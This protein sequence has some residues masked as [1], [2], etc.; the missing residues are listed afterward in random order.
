MR[1]FLL[2]F[3]L[4]F[5]ASAQTKAYLTHGG[6][7]QVTVMDTATDINLRT[8]LGGTTPSRVAASRDGGRVYVANTGNSTISVIDTLSDTIANTF[9]LS[10]VPNALAVSANGALLYVSVPNSIQVLSTF[11]GAVTASIPVTGTATGLAVTPDG[12][13]LFAAAGRLL[14]ID[15]ATNAVTNTGLA[16]GAT[17]VLVHPKANRVF[18]QINGFESGS[19]AVLDRASLQVTN[20]ILMGSMG[21]MAIS[22]D[23]SRLY[24]GAGT[25]ISCGPYICSVS[26]G[27][28]VSVI[29]TYDLAVAG[30]IPLNGLGP[31]A[32][33]AVTPDRSDVYIVLSSFNQVGVASTSSN[34]LRLQIP[35]AAGANQITILTDPNAPI[36]PYLID[37]VDDVAPKSSSGGT[38]VANV[39][40][41]DRLGGFQARLTNVTLSQVSSTSFGFSLNASTGAAVVAAGTAYGPQSLVYRICETAAPTNCD[42]A[43]VSVSVRA[44]YPIDAVDDSASSNTGRVAI[45]NVLSN[46]TFNGSPAN[47]T[48][49]TLGQVS[50]TTTALV[51][52]ANGSVTVLAGAPKGPQA[53]VYRICEIDSPANCDSATATVTVIP[54][55]IDAVDDTGVTTRAGGIAV[56][57]V[58]VNDTFA[59]S[60][61]TLSRVTLTQVSTSNAGLTL[62]S[63]GSVSAARGIPMGTHTL[64][65]RICETASPSNCDSAAVTVNVTSYVIDAVDDVA[66]G[67]SKSANT[68]L[69]SVLAN[70]T[71]GGVQP[72]TATVSL[73]KVSLTPANSSI[74]LN[75]VDGSVN[76]LGKTTSGM[77]SLVYRIC[78][79]AN[80]GNCDQATVSLDLSGR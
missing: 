46:D 14:A 79:I 23:G 39:L 52:G 77:Y 38:A 61:A 18:A 49:V 44:P 37:A 70:D 7:N 22:P 59:G 8:I 20:S 63:N 15:T 73:T 69:A 42:E 24:V 13:Q 80:P 19:I 78:E 1:H 36:T 12:A 55:A 62:G 64:V 9:P 2:A 30:F 71:L 5:S 28:V 21:Q 11:T 60:A 35:V 50:S 75:L 27:Q 76:V 48:N 16:A 53:L 4:C 40:A 43:T 45:A 51:L 10:A 66:R 3:G 6:T 32:G 34:T 68:V 25:T 72:T 47:L 54:F 17:D 67:S 65:Y 58:L 56:A 29:D 41:N 31:A 57:N 26:V 33:I 74:Q